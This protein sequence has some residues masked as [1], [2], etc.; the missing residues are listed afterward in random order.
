MSACEAYRRTYSG[1]RTSFRQSA[2][3]SG[4]A[5]AGRY[6]VSLTAGISLAAARR[7]AADALYQV[8]KGIVVDTESVRFLPPRDGYDP[9]LI[10]P[11]GLPSEPEPGT[12]DITTANIHGAQ[13]T[14]LKPDGSGKADVEPK[15]ITLGQCV[16]WP[17]VLAPPSDMMALTI[18]EGVED[19]LTAHVATG[20]GAWASGGAGRLPALADKVPSYM[21]LMR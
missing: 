18:A 6:P 15:K 20:R 14:K 17:I 7:E 12:L 21:T 19:A 3:Q 1:Q 8:E 9:A 10:V 13:L 5:R 16:G 11:F 2:A 4:T